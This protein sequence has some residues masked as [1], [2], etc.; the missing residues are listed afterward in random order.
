[1]RVVFDPE[2]Q[3]LWQQ[4]YITQAKQTGY[5]LQGFQ[6]VQYQRGNGLG[7]LFKGLFRMILPVAKNVGKA[8]GTQAL[9]TGTDFAADVLTGTPLKEAAKLHGKAGL[10]NLIGK[11]QAHLQGGNR[12]GKVPKRKPNKVN[13]TIRKKKQTKPKTKKKT[14]N[15][16]TTS[17]E[18]S[19]IVR[20]KPN[21]K[22]SKK[23]IFSE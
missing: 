14:R 12:I 23:D 9:R 11:A 5:G 15:S 1:M 3:L 6:G 10:A 13:N 19:L 16:N 20:K 7:S 4:Y 21:A 8:I 18:N 2:S 22:R 17:W